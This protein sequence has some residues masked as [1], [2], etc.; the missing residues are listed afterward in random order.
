M[1]HKKTHEFIMKSIENEMSIDSYLIK[2]LNLKKK[3]ISY[4]KVARFKDRIPLII[5]FPLILVMPFYFLWQ[6]IKSL[7]VKNEVLRGNDQCLFMSFSESPKVNGL[8]RDYANCLPFKQCVSGRTLFF[9]QEI[10]LLNILKSFL[11][12][13][14][15]SARFLIAVHPR[16]YLHVTSV[17]ELVSFSSYLDKISKDGIKEITLTNH[18]DRWIT[19]ICEK[20]IFSVNVI[21]HGLLANDFT[22]KH[23]LRNIKSFR[24]IN[25]D[26]LNIYASNIVYDSS[27]EKLYLKTSLD[28]I[29]NDI[30]DILII[31]NP[32]Y[33]ADELKIYQELKNYCVDVKFRPHPLYITS[34]ILKSI[35][36]DDLCTD[37][38]LPNPSYCLCKSS[39]L[40]YE[41]EAMGYSLITWDDEIDVNSILVLLG[42]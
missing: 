32:F 25:D 24:G 31:S 3:W 13:I 15:C 41:Y 36:V 11:T 40:G 37:K 18:Y 23:K 35:N 16:F 30:C 8:Y 7:K 28:I 29:E 26:Q 2:S 33:I 14:I 1:K 12:S 5:T 4:F 27:F 21:Q 34:E 39:T 42:K 17:F 19:L 20:D 22:Q 6:I 9:L 10:S 38:R